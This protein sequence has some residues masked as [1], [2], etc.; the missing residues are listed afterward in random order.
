MSAEK[1]DTDLREQ[2][3]EIAADIMEVDVDRIGW[4]T[5]FWDELDAD[6]MQGI[7][8]LSALERR[9]GITIEQNALADMQDV[10]S[11]SEVVMA[12]MKAASPDG[13]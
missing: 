5:H 11:T 13:P 7:E 12:I 1:T 2:I 6:S 4:T 3:R 9:F 10:Q 8:L